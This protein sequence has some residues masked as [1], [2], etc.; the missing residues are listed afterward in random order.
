MFCK[1]P[2]FFTFYIFLFP[3]IG[4]LHYLRPLKK[5]KNCMKLKFISLASGSSGNCFYLGSPSYGILI[6]AGIG[7]RTIKKV[8]RERGIALETVLGLFVTHDHA[9]HI[10]GAGNLSEGCNIPVYTTETIHKG[11][12][13]SYCMTKKVSPVNRRIIQKGETTIVRD[14]QITP[15]E[16][17]HD[18]TDNVGYSIQCEGVNFCFITDIGHIT[19]EVRK[20]VAEAHYLILEANYDEQMLAEGPYPPL[21][22]ARI[23]GPNGHLSNREAG[24]FLAESYP[25]L[26]RQLWLCHLSKENNTPHLA[27]NTVKDSLEAIGKTVGQ[28]VQLM[29]LPRTSPTVVFEIDTE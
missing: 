8:L 29:A 3:L 18:G 26:L 24:R 2:A 25:P 28:D 9:D 6:D 27:Y 7:I 17:P 12:M 20:H 15:F 19:E 5:Q 11:M 13:K 4:Y 21:L 14:F 10:R 22:Q 1:K 23:S 16:I